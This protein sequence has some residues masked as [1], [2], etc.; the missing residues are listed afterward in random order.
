MLG[1][2]KGVG[3]DGHGKDCVLP[4]VDGGEFVDVAIELG[5]C[6]VEV[7]GLFAKQGDE[8]GGV[9]VEGVGLY[10][11]ERLPEVFVS[12]RRLS[13]PEHSVLDPDAVMVLQGVEAEATHMAE[14]V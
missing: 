5:K 4:F 12:P 14:P 6:G 2:D 8:N 7:R 1:D 9:V 11:V 3:L 13:E 10:V